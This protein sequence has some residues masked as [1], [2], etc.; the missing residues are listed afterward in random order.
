MCWA[1]VVVVLATAALSAGQHGIT[2]LAPSILV[3]LALVVG[4]SMA[5]PSGRAARLADR[6]C[7]LN[8][9]ADTA[10]HLAE[11]GHPAAEAV[12][13]DALDALKGASPPPLR[14]P[15]GRWV[16]LGAVLVTSLG[17][18]L[19]RLLEPEPE[20]EPGAAEEL[21]ARLDEVEDEARRKGQAEL[22]EA[23]Q[24]L[25]ERV[26]AVQ[27]P[28][29]VSP[30][31]PV[32]RHAVEPPPLP[33]PPVPVE[34]ETPVPAEFE[35]RQEYE[36]AIDQAQFMMSQDEELLAEFSA[37]IQDRLMEITQF[38]ELGNDLLAETLRANEINAQLT[39]QEFTSTQ[40]RFEGAQ[41]DL[42]SQAMQQA[43]QMAPAM[44]T[45]E[46]APD[47][48]D[49]AETAS[50]AHE[51]ALALQ[52]SYQD[53]LEAYAD[54]LRDELIEAIEEAHE[55]DDQERDGNLD[56]GGTPSSSSSEAKSDASGAAELQVR[57]DMP[58]ASMTQLGNIDDPSSKK[59]EGMSGGSGSPDQDDG[60]PSSGGGADAGPSA[61][62]E[63][64]GSEGTPGGQLE[65][66][67]G[68]LGPGNM[69][70]QQRAQVLQGI[71]EKAIQ[72]GPG[73]DF[74]EV[75]SGYFDEVERALS[76]EDMPPMMQ[77]A[78]VAYFSGLK[79]ESP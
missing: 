1:S 4:W 57:E 47:K 6:S 61:D 13:L 54:A 35:T 17:L 48:R 15:A 65:Q 30:V 33:P 75:W 77:S 78:V 66:L 58:P 44:S 56:L 62:K 11:Q 46:M 53:F 16:L 14:P 71:N 19:G 28:S 25:R 8:A 18:G 43:D 50:N 22:V 59:L 20:P 36:Q 37:E 64:S 9:T 69:S 70:E 3:I 51:L 40:T 10:L 63:R 29:P 27:K 12:A 23:V 49:L 76:E 41:Q 79:E 38:E 73:S 72:T 7:G 52:A 34:E 68:G 24:D 39:G 45:S 32:A 74:D 26:R 60:Q 31:E 5:V 42:M 21:L 55:T 67:Q 2:L